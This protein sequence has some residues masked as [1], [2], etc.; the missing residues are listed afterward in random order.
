[1]A[2]AQVRIN[3]GALQQVGMN[4]AQALVTRTTRRTFNR[5][6]VTVP[7]DTGI[8]RASGGWRVYRVAR[9]WRGEV[10]YTARY[11]AAVHNGRRALTIRARGR[12][13]MRFVVDGQVV[14]AR[15]VRQPARAARP[16]LA[17]S[18]YQVAVP[19]GFRVST[20]IN[21]DF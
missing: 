16:F 5:S 1:M 18:L 20:G 9:S 14:Y 4:K 17:V 7:V 2:W 8:L 11:A 3:R 19:A 15:S 10:D 12:K 6:Q 13:A 21:L